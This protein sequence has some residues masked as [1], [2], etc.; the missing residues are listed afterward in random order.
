[1]P[2][3][4]QQADAECGDHEPEE[5]DQALGPPVS[6]RPPPALKAL[7]ASQSTRHWSLAIAPGMGG[8]A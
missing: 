6:A 1:V 8:Q 5:T 3:A 4:N 7:V 2:S